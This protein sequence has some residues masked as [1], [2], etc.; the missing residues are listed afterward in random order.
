MSDI[1]RDLN[2]PLY[3]WTQ[4]ITHEELHMLVQE[5][6]M[7]YQDTPWWRL[8]EKLMLR[9]AVSSANVLLM[10][11]HGGKPQDVPFVQNNRG[12]GGN[13]ETFNS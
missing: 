2:R 3:E 10:W 5:M 13:H 8:K 4:V 9:G 12:T 11:L 1:E 6:Y 7:A